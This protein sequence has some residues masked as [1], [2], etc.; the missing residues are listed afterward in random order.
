MRMLI[1]PIVAITL[2]AIDSLGADLRDTATQEMVDYQ[3]SNTVGDFGCFF[4]KG[5]KDKN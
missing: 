4:L 3:K 5:I 2:W 1:M